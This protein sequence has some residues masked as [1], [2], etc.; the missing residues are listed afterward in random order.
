MIRRRGIGHGVWGLALAGLL[1]FCG[2]LAGVPAQGFEA[3]PGSKNFSTPGSVPNYFSNEAAPLGEGPQTAQP[4]VDRFNTAPRAASYAHSAVS[5]PQPTH[6]TAA[7][8]GRGTHHTR[9][10]RGGSGRYRFAAARHGQAYVGKTRGKPVLLRASATAASRK[11]VAPSY[12]SR[13]RHAPRGA[14]YAH[15]KYAHRGSR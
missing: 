2:A 8:A 9:I 12:A 1:I 3:P 6:S 4:G 13:S 5:V 14:K 11:S 15:T 7:S 10:T